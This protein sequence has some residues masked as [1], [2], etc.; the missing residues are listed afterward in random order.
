M[1]AVILSLPTIARPVGE[2]NSDA[3]ETSGLDFGN[4]ESLNLTL[5]E[6]REFQLDRKIAAVAPLNKTTT[7]IA[8][9]TES[10]FSSAADTAVALPASTG[11]VT[12]ERIS[13]IANSGSSTSFPADVDKLRE[14]VEPVRA[15]P[16]ATTSNPFDG[17]LGG[18]APTANRAPAVLPKGDPGLSAFAEKPTS[19]FGD[20]GEQTFATLGNPGPRGENRDENQGQSQDEVDQEQERKDREAFEEALSDLAGRQKPYTF[21]DYVDYRDFVA[22]QGGPLGQLDLSASDFKQKAEEIFDGFEK[23]DVSSET[24]PRKTIFRDFVKEPED[25]AQRLIAEP[26]TRDRESAGKKSSH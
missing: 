15:V 22:E 8:T 10:G 13:G 5:R 21:K 24:A 4:L 26:K 6:T 18:A 20:R 11:E 16:G 9:P 14:L 25:P 7:P 12:A 2:Q 23:R 19:T 3:T 17:Y 1:S